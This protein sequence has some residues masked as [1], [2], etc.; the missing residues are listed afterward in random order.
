MTPL[1]HPHQNDLLASLPAVDF[2]PL[3]SALECVPLRLGDMVYVPGEPLR[4]VVF[5]LSLIHI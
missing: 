5:P 4:H 1:H 3:T 2:A